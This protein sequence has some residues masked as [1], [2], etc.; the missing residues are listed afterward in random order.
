MLIHH[1]YINRRAVGVKTIVLLVSCGSAH[2]QL[3][4][5]AYRVLGQKNFN[6]SNV[7]MVQ[8]V[9]LNTPDSI[10]LDTRGSQVHLYISDTLN[11]R[12][13]A[14]PDVNSYQVGDR[15]AIILGQSSPQGTT[16]MGI[17][18]KGL[19]SPLGLAVDPKTGNLYVADYYANRVVRFPSP[20]DNPTRIEPDA[21]YG[22]PNFTATSAATPSATSLNGPRSVACD[23]SG[24]LWVA[25][26]GNNR[27]LRFPVASLNASAPVTADTVIG[28]SGFI[29]GSPDGGG[30]PSNTGFDLP[31]GIA[32]DAQS[33]LYVA[34]Y[35]NNRVLRFAAPSGPSTAAI[36]AS[37]VWGQTNF[38]SNIAPAPASASSL[39]GPSGVAV[40][41]NGNLYVATPGSNRVLGF[42]AAGPN[43]SAAKIVIGQPDFTTTTSNTN[44]FPLASPST[45]ASPQDVKVDA[46]GNVYVADAGNNR[47]VVFPSGSKS[48]DNVWGQNDFVSNGPNE[49]KPASLNYPYQVAIDYSQSPF[50]L[51]VS[52]TGNN[53]VLIWKDS[54]HFRSGDPADLA[55]GQP[56]LS[57]AA[58]NVDSGLA[59][60]PTSTSLSNPAGIAVSGNG[61]LYVADSANNR[62]LRYP[63][64]V[65][66]NGRIAPDAVIGQANFT[67]STFA[68]VNATS[69]DRPTGL[70]IGPNGDL[71]VSDSGNN[72]V[73]EF[74]AGGGTGSAA[75]RVYGQQNLTSANRPT[76]I[77][78]QTLSAPQG[79]F[80]DQASNLYVADAGSNRVV[81]FPNTQSAP[82][83][84]SVAAAVIG[85]ADF[86][87]TPGPVGFKTPVGV[88]V[89][90]SGS[91]Y[92]GDSGNNRVLIF[93]W[94]G[95][96][97]AGAA[98]TGV[99]GQQSRAGTTSNW[100]SSN[101]QATADGLYNPIAVYLDRQDT[102]YVGDTGNS[103][104][105]QFLKAGVLLNAASL[106]SNVPIAAGSIATLIGP[107]LVN[108]SP[109]VSGSS[110]PTALLN[111][112]VVIND[113][114]VSPLYYFGPTQV[115]FQI[116]S[117]TPPGQQRVAVRTADTNEL[118]AG[119]SL[120]AASVAP[121][122]FTLTETGSG[123]AAVL[124]QD[125]TVNGAGNPAA[126]GSVIQIY[127]T[128]QGQVSPPV[129]DGTAASGSPT[130][131]TVAV[132]T[133]SA[134]T[135]FA[136]Q[137]SMCIAIGG[138]FGN[139]MYSG[140][141]PGAIGLW[142]INVTIPSGIATGNAVPMR[143]VIDGASSNLVTIAVK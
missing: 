138:A 34:D 142:Q 30:A 62:V 81:I 18:S 89:D 139:I 136:T 68:A 134:Q 127:G 116:P 130:S 82:A 76:Q 123:Q 125:N 86:S 54:A 45:L 95:Y 37:V 47:V 84:G 48:A 121:A 111:R 71:F 23:S 75:I 77:S 20:F 33:N 22:Q 53:R 56:N 3:F 25:D 44:A 96:L 63:R 101:G 4:S 110:W 36:A 109:V 5:S 50:A 108:Q 132:D 102:L 2:A 13:L 28:Q 137:P 97:T 46:N 9:E 114:L 52:D 1:K 51:Y 16:P 119:G 10:A 126:I 128:G 64:P 70:A 141:A 69:L 129:S 39:S 32:F 21:V 94:P 26:T 43:G 49:V 122:I 7:N 27:V 17:G 85:Q 93:S 113:Q 8:G 40:D 79:V 78:A 38:T 88:G 112:Q 87:G 60:T 98:A 57:T 12:I 6:G 90:S 91:V 135:C 65:N 35:N 24:N 106:Q 104:L 83:A 61:T 115:N 59:A 15:P 55:I 41:A 117:N 67:S 73:L 80:V 143:V 120:I 74:S 131:N 92:V 140:L 118:I 99:V 105:L 31:A 100:D 133:T 58:A 72:R 11:S 124:N 66:Q 107:G 29:S 103:R 14:W 19:N 42:S